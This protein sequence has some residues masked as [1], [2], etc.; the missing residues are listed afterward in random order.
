MRPNGDIS[1]FDPVPTQLGAEDRRSIL[2]AQGWIAE[3]FG[4]YAYLEIGSY[5]GGSLQPHL[6]DPRCEIVY[7]VDPRP[8]LMR[9]ER[10]LLIEYPDNTTDRMIR[11]LKPSYA[12][13]LAKLRTFDMD[14]RSL[15]KDAIAPRPRICFIDGEHT[16]H[17]VL[18]DF[19]VCLDLVEQ[20]GVIMFD[21]A[22][23]VYGA[24]ARCI[25]AL[26][27]RQLEHRAYVLPRKIGV[28]EVGD[29]QLYRQPDVISML[30]TATPYLAL[31]ET[32][33]PYRQRLVG[34]LGLPIVRHLRR[35][36]VHILTRGMPSGGT[37]AETDSTR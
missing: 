31:A 32:L 18:S 20:P 6:A 5:L 27:D 3:R 19:S 10:G 37:R 4:T 1:V 9:D 17:A 36:R 15:P 29:L 34:F 33:D 8:R 13:R 30:A 11:A 12:N 16:D 21:D 22:N 2:A 25:A 7:S 35:L 14:A 24:L 23:L 28:I 26:K